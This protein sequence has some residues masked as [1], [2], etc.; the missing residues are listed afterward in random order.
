[1]NNLTES[2]VFNFGLWCGIILFT[3]LNLLTCLES[4]DCF[5]NSQFDLVSG[6][7]CYS[8]FPLFIYN[9][10]IGNPN[11]S[12]IIWSGLFDNILIALIF[13]FVLGLIFKF[14]WSKI[15]SHRSPLK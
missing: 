6:A 14:V 4:R 1:M 2:R 13:S 9:A 7:G 12:Y 11:N 5:L 8:G 15:F 3:V 10:G